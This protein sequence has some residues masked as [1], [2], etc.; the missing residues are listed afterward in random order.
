MTLR[1]QRRPPQQ[2]AAD[3]SSAEPS[4][5]CRQDAGSTLR[6]M[7]SLDLQ[8]RT[9]IGAM[10]RL[11]EVGRVTPCAPSFAQQER[12]VAAVG[13]QRTARPTFRFMGSLDLQHWTR[14]VALNRL[15]EVGRVT[16]RA[17][18]AALQKGLVARAGEQRTA[19]PAF[20][21]TEGFFCF[22]EGESKTQR[23]SMWHQ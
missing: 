23:I 4:F 10:N 13:A 1:N 15:A 12:V 16:P 21:P 6:F 3:V 2:R 17:P 14:I 9:R 11:A 22:F 19:G 18:S 20:L 8:D 5:F 7:E